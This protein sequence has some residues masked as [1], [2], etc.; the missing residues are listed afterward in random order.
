[1]AE[2]DQP[3]P[4]KVETAESRHKKV[5][6]SYATGDA[7]FVRRLL[8]ALR[9]A[10][11]Q[12]AWYDGLEIAD[13]TPNIQQALRDGI[14]A[15]DVF[16]LVLTPRAAERPWLSYEI[17]AAE[18][19]VVEMV[20]ILHDLPNGFGTLAER[21]PF[22]ARLLPR[23]RIDLDT[24]FES[25]I[26]RV[27]LAVAPELGGP[28]FVER[29]LVQLINSEDPDDA[30]SAASEIG[31]QPDLFL[32]N[33]RRQL[34]KSREGRRLRYR[35]GRAFAYIGTDSID[36]LIDILV[37]QVDAAE[38]DV[39]PPPE[40]LRSSEDDPRALKTFTGNATRDY[41]QW[42]ILSGGNLR[43]A[44]QVGAENALIDLAA[45]AT[46]ARNLIKSSLDNWLRLAAARLVAN[47]GAEP[48]DNAIDA[49]RLTIE[50]L[51]IIGGSAVDSFLI[52][53]FATSAFWSPETVFMIDKLGKYVV[54]C[55]GR[56]GDGR[57]LEELLFLS[58]DASM[59][60]HFFETNRGL[61]PWN[62]V[63]VSFGNQAVDP[64][65][66][67]LSSC[68]SSFRPFLIDNLSKMPNARAHAVVFQELDSADLSDVKRS[69]IYWALAASHVRST[70][71]HIAERYLSGRLDALAADGRTE[72]QVATTLALVAKDM[73]DE[74]GAA[75][76][77]KE[78]ADTSYASTQ[79]EVIRTVE[80]RRLHRHYD[81]VK[82]WFDS[83][84][85]P[86]V[87]GTAAISLASLGVIVDRNVFYEKITDA[88][89]DVEAPHYG[90]ALSHYQDV[91]AIPA[92]I[93]GLRHS[94]EHSREME[95]DLYAEALV[96]VGT[97][98]AADARRKWYRRA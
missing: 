38:S 53:E 52:R 8:S 65:I 4:S 94:F 88:N 14:A 44:S 81:L 58:R 64:L 45:S 51:G 7:I 42:L 67:A 29:T 77:V 43:F 3:P 97:D 18:E 95:H 87:R 47:R 2:V 55:L 70:A 35:L 41:I 36:P 16:A 78:L 28:R 10:G 91:R 73:A 22:I 75:E 15:C 17:Q 11:F 61:N 69:Q 96:R 84:A 60:E 12:E 6:I 37:G 40:L 79:R 34:P 72:E 90:V 82:T 71:D 1:V 66:S 27:L 24:D 50:T 59:V 48:T 21:N 31:L 13:T 54:E 83:A 98:D 26:T 46:G 68:S 62:D 86:Q 49:L 5:F 92:L 33:L 85:S 25:G 89:P 76:I 30:E 32:S 20:V 23:R 39:P 19:F 80:A 74:T 56:I 57:A 63:F 93:H 9:Q